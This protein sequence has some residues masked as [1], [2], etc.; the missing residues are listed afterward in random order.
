MPL[1]E[2]AV[3]KKPTRKQIDE[4]TGKEELLLSPKAVVAPNEM[5]AV[6]KAVQGADPPIDLDTAE[7]LVRPFAG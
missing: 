5:T 3:L 1:F 2:I 6:A 7:V 4:G